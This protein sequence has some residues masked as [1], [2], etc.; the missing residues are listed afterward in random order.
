MTSING[1]NKFTILHWN[2]NGITTYS[3]IKQME[4]LLTNLD[5]QIAGLNETFFKERHKPYF[6]N[7]TLLR[8]DRMHRSGG[9]VALL[10]HKS[11]SFKQLPITY[12]STIE[13]LSV[14][15]NIN[16]R[17]IIVSTAYCPKYSSNFTNDIKALTPTDK[18]FILLGDLNAKHVSWNCH[19]NNVSGTLLNQLQQNRNFF[20]YHPD[21]Y[22]LYPHRRGSRPSTVDII[23]SNL[24][25][26]MNLKTLDFEIPSDHRPIV[27]HIECNSYKKV[28]TNFY[29]Y[30]NTNWSSFRSV[31]DQCITPTLERYRSRE[32]IDKEIK[33]FR[34]LILSARDIS[35]PSSNMSPISSLPN[36]VMHYIHQRR[37]L[38]RKQ[39]R[40][41]DNHQFELYGQ[42]IK[43][44]T[45]FIDQRINNL[46]NQKWSNLL[47]R[48]KPGDKSFWKISRTLRCKNRR[49]IPS[50]KVGTA[51]FI[52]DEEKSE[53]LA[54]TFAKA[55]KLTLDYKHSIDTLVN[56]TAE[57][58]KTQN[59]TTIN[60]DFI[61]SNELSHVL[62]KL[63]SSK[64]PGFDKIPNIL[65][66][67][68][69]QKAV[70]LLTCLFNSC[71]QLN[72]FPSAFKIAKII[73]VQKPNK[74]T[75]NPSNY[76]PI[77]LLSNL[78]KV[79]E[80]LI[81]ARIETF[82]ATNNIISEKQ[83]GFKK[84]H[85]TIHQIGRIK[86]KI[87]G[88]KILKKSTGM[89]LLDIE[90][91]FDSVWHNGLLYKLVS[92]NMPMYLCKIIANFLEHRQFAVSV[93][94]SISS[95]KNMPSGLPQGSILSPILYS[96]FTSDFKPNKGTD[97][98]YYADDTALLSSSKL[99]GA[100]LKKMEYSLSVCSKYFKKWKIKI[101]H[102]KTQCII[103]P[104]N[105]SPKRT[106]TR[107]LIFEG[108]EISI[109]NEVKYL[110]VILDKKLLF[111]K[112]IQSSCEKAM[113]SFRALWPIL[114][115]RSPLNL[116]NKNLIFKCVLRPILAFASPIWHRAAK[117]HLKRLQTM[118]NKSLKMIF[119]KPWRYPTSILHDETGY[120]LFSDFIKRLNENYFL[121]IQN[122]HYSIIRECKD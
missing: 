6:Q 15:V 51:S 87:V 53:L 83:F 121:R 42:F 111:H 81:H 79:F 106:P 65:L 49:T 97:V 30:K 112:H 25:L 93:N 91:A 46:R 37:V 94:N 120:E 113:K 70:H 71:I 24:S 38:K 56:T 22:T 57:N 66:K 63:K 60:A 47:E 69:P 8:N 90:K 62:L 59:P 55:H 96:I 17:K 14:E 77:S 7:Y 64:S 104:F 108:N 11:I 72:Y 85:S 99:T 9:G 4:T 114:N 16:K 33:N 2:A 18:E 86:N 107:Q 88:N 27:C 101:N 116:K 67:R 29:T 117:S 19:N 98:A 82:A 43:L 80:K 92:V 76:R 23:L 34:K 58:L 26:P 118:Q 35:T 5:I 102:L 61:N 36:D 21:S 48:L 40:T 41:N 105:K 13:N 110:G 78:G 68:L 44:L 84:H 75:T 73:P 74:I 100:L 1:R 103:F 122:S 32:S 10:I 20:I 119:N 89:I 31:I 12:T 54:N 52:T 109:Q 39:Q 45:K 3:H 95:F 28:E 50:L 115:R